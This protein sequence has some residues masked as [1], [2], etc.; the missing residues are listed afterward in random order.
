MNNYPSILIKLSILN[1]H[2]NN[3]YTSYIKNAFLHSSI[4]K[5]RWLQFLSENIISLESNSLKILEDQINLQLP[6][7]FIKT[8]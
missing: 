2:N 4:R 3:H 7:L 8:C 6:P 5:R 1:L